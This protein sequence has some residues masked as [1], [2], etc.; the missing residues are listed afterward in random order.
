MADAMV[1]E[2]MKNADVEI[3]WAEL[4]NYKLKFAT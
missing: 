3:T 1:K 4:K 2:V